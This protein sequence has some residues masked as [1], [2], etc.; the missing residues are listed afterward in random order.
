M[1]IKS[2]HKFFALASGAIFLLVFTYVFLGGS[3]IYA[4]DKPIK[5]KVL[6]SWG[7]EHVHVRAFVVP[8]VERLNKKSG[9]RL[10]VS[11][12]GPEAVPPFEQ[13]K[14]LSAGLFDMVFTHP[15]YHM[16]EVAIGVAMD[17]F[18]ASPQE[19]WEAGFYNIID[20]G[21]EKV[22]AQVLANVM[23]KGV[24]YH[25]MLKKKCI[26]K[27]DF[28]GLKLRTTP[29][30]D[31]LA[32]GLGAATVKVS[33]GEIYSAL[34]KGVVDGAFWVVMGALDY[35]WYEVA[36]YQLRPQFGEVAEILLV[37]KKK[38]DSLP[39]DVQ[40]MIHEITMEVAEE[41][42]QDLAKTWKEEEEKLESLGMKLCVLPPAEGEK[43]Q[44][45]YYERSW[46]EIVLKHSQDLGPKLKKSV[47]QFMKG[48]QK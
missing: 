40:K 39:K 13:L 31:P 6:S 2:N 44:K 37:N 18:S 35:K 8:Y 25:L 17:L 12:V 16:G 4:A 10:D 14:P 46:E 7:P 9:G 41:T 45:T 5:L 27:A 42:Y 3:V 33:G 28:T 11:W 24:G 26:D 43:L 38:W 29:S 48:R 21:Y 36:N 15:A 19:R 1:K 22:N 20:E 32:K 30:Y 47:D 34:E 23:G